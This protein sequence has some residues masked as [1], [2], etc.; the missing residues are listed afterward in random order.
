[1]KFGL[2]ILLVCGSFVG[3]AEVTLEEK[4]GQLLMVHFNGEG[5][6]EDAR[7]L[8]QE[9][10]VGGI[11]YYT[12]ANGL[13]SPQQ[14]QSL[15]E[16]LQELAE[17]PLLIAIDQEGGNVVRLTEGFTKVPGNDVVGSSGDPSM[18]QAVAE[19][20]GGE[21]RAVGINMNLAPVVDVYSDPD[22]PLGPR[23]FSSDPE[24][25]ATFGH[26]AIIGYH[27]QGVT[28]TLK[29]FPGH[30]G[31]SIDSHEDLPVL[32]KSL[33]ELESL[34]LI[35]F[36]RL[37]P[38][39]DAIMT[40]HILVPAL[41]QVNCAT[42]SKAILGLLREHLGFQGVIISDSLVMSGVL[43]CTG[44]VDEAAKQALIAGCDILLLGGKLFHGTNSNEVS[45]EDIE[46]IKSYLVD[47]V[48]KGD[49]DLQR[50]DDAYNRVLAL[51][52][53]YTDY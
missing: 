9:V 28:T 50:V 18:A 1:M 37:S 38:H 36:A 53:R 42:L 25:V 51:K 7:K 52:K 3:A 35:P 19:T 6:N 39:T 24:T 16:V 20:I 2:M 4:V 47:G 5:V 48:R 43:K 17:T 34:E 23:C 46:R 32:V 8:I 15:S 22:S 13:R 29:H 26:R 30:G 49:I 40:A 31:V 45:V 12:W 21:L 41:D 44:S 14:V 27:N 11:I 33:D 10:K